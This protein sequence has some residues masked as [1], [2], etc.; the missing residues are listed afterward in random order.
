[1]A[2][3]KKLTEEEKEQILN[4]AMSKIIL[5]K[6]DQLDTAIISVDCPT[7]YPLE[8]FIQKIRLL[9]YLH[10]TR[11]YL[12]DPTFSSRIREEC[13]NWNEPYFKKISFPYQ[14]LLDK[15][16]P[17]ILVPETNSFF[18]EDSTH[19]WDDPEGGYAVVAIE[20]VVSSKRK[21]Y[22]AAEIIDKLT[23]MDYD[24]GIEGVV[25]KSV[26]SQKQRSTYPF[27]PGSLLCFEDQVFQAKLAV[28][29][30]SSQC[31]FHGLKRKETSEIIEDLS[32]LYNWKRQKSSN[33]LKNGKKE[34][35]LQ[36]CR[37]L[38]F[39]EIT[40]LQELFECASVDYKSHVVTSIL[41]KGSSGVVYKVYSR[42]L[43]AF[44]AL[45]VFVEKDN[46]EEEETLSIEA[47]LMAKLSGK[48]LENIVQIYTAGN[49][50]TER[51]KTAYTINMEYVDGQTLEEILS[52]RKL[53]THEVLD[54][55]AQI[56][57]G[58]QSLRRWGI[59][60]RDLNPRNIKVNSLG[61]IKILDFGIATDEQSP[62][63]KDNRRYGASEGNNADD[64][65]SFGLLLYKMVT[66]E[67]LVYTKTAEVGEE[68]YIK[69]IARLKSEIYSED[70]TIKREYREKIAA[71][72]E[73]PYRSLTGS[74]TIVCIT[75]EIRKILFS[76]FEKEEVDQIKH[77][78][79]EPFFF[80]L[81]S[82]D[83]LIDILW[84]GGF[85]ASLSAYVLKR[86]K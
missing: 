6:V 84:N 18:H 56:L 83:E 66:N 61:K 12:D 57:N 22:S 41:G 69:N 73:I 30:I 59:T 47:Q 26:D 38:N 28:K 23:P 34:T 71:V 21:K 35:Y 74:E 3:G 25:T 68:T 79:P 11:G 14:Q 4:A 19:L 36:L 17:F 82:R 77:L 67:H 16:K 31:I 64:L 10:N 70:G 48:D 72:G 55:S 80:Y 27:I 45:K 5:A 24:Y 85:S 53:T 54:Y 62:K 13:S 7:D 86:K 63:A 2:L 29:Y 9:H 37:I 49:M 44:R 58:I 39:G 52:E 8:A 32:C 51:W 20:T 60:H 75:P 1:M 33:S 15:R 65:F 81:C 42:E 50:V 78:Y 76:C 40:T 43:N 46:F